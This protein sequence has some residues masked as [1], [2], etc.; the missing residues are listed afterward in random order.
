MAKDT[1]EN[2]L[3]LSELLPFSSVATIPTLPSDHVFVFSIT[4]LYLKKRQI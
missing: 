3:L 2:E 4:K 1:K